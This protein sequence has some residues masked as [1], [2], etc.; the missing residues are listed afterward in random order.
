MYPTA[1]QTAGCG[2]NTLNIPFEINMHNSQGT[3]T[4]SAL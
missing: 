2:R 1:Q 3:I 4:P